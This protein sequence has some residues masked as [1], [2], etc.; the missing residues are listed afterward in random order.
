MEYI[1]LL[2][3]PTMCVLYNNLYLSRSYMRKVG[4]SPSKDSFGLVLFRVSHYFAINPDFVVNTG[5]G[6]NLVRN[7]ILA[8]NVELEPTM[9]KFDTNPTTCVS[10]TSFQQEGERYMMETK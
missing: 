5:S 10:P 2:V 6:V 1:I 7:Y 9:L 4:G 3:K 8:P